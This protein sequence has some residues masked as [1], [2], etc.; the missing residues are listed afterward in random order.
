MRAGDFLA[1]G[2][3]ASTLTQSTKITPQLV[4][5][6]L[7]QL[8]QFEQQLNQWLK[9]KDLMPVKIGRPV[10]STTYYQR[11]LEQ[12]PTREYGD[13][14]VNMF[15]PKLPGISDNAN[16]STYTASIKEFADSNPNYSTN[17]GTNVI[18]KLGNDYV[19]VDFVI[20]YYDAEDWSRALGPEYNVKGV[21]SASLS[22]SL[23]EALNISISGRGVQVKLRNGAPVSFRQ[24][25]D[26]ELK[27]I[28]KNPQTWA[29]DIAKFFGA[30]QI[31]NRLQ[32]YP[33][34]GDEVRTLDL[35]NSIKGIAESLGK[36]EIVEQVKA[37]YADK[38]NRAINNSK[39]DKAET[40]AAM[41]KAEDT[42]ALL[43]QGMERILGQFNES[44]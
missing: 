31:S 3:W 38:I 2:G 39:F 28:T 16:E 26:V 22:S 17:N 25:R 4:D 24:T 11:D 42:K 34:M 36:P 23:A 19:Q 14:D 18:L 43:A 29:L 12:N 40:P 44:T 7:K 30:E 13:I 5:I 41:K 33:G 35:V 9:T 10:G 1:E 32:Q 6:V 20:S 37:I 8:P 27:T 15:I 21:L